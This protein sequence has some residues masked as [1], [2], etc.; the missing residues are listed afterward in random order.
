MPKLQY[1]V[2]EFNR[3]RGNL[4]E[5]PV[6]NMFVEQSPT[7]DS[8]VLQSRPGL[9]NSGTSMGAGPVKALFQIDGVLDGSLFGISAGALYKNGTSLGTVNGTG[10][11][12]IDGFENRLF[13]TQGTSLYQYDGT[14]FAT[15]ATPG[16]FQ[17]L[18]LCVGTS[19]L[20][21]INKDT[22]KFYWSDVLSNNIDTLSFATA[23]NSPDKLKEM[24]FIGDT[25]HLFGTE[26]VEFWPA[27]SA[28]PDLPYQ[29]VVGR[30]YSVGIRTTGCATKFGPTFA[31]ITDQNQVCV[32]NPETVISDSGLD[33]KIAASA[34]A[35][36]WRF[37]LD[38]VEFLAVTLDAETWVFNKKSSQWSTF[39]SD[40]QTNW[41]PRCYE[42]GKFGSGINGNLVQW[43]TD[44]QDFAGILERRFRAGLPITS[45]VIPLYSV[46]LKANPGRT[47]FSEPSTY[48]TPEVSLRTSK[49]GG[50]TWTA[51]KTISLGTAAQYRKNLRWTSLG[52]F[53]TPGILVEI[54]VTD[55]VPFR[56]SGLMA[57]DALATV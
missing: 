34:T 2:S 18:S 33:E 57:N 16:G 6:V 43:A 15:L 8:V 31:W 53:G 19:R 17:V 7:E 20:I 32:T 22:G 46:E 56:V 37:Y 47:P 21:I 44:H 10:P 36:L 51:W 13:C 3:D 1:A 45:G 24:L 40:G 52:F 30:T 42:N 12:R 54:K 39:A 26:T 5:L 28:N 55:P 38:G 23:E 41:I 9:T 35:S 48:A 25:L 14:T 4:P 27:S 29:P 11:A 49:D 50:E